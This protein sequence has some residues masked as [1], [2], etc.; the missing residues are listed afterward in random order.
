[1]A[2][3][4]DLNKH[5]KFIPFPKGMTVETFF[6]YADYNGCE[7]DVIGTALNRKEGVFVRNI[8]YKAVKKTIEQAAEFFNED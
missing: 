7:Y 6:D 8:D 1:M 2:K 4:I 5:V 3:K